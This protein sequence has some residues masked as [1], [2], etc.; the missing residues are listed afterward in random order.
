MHARMGVTR[1]DIRLPFRRI[2]TWEDAKSGI[3]RL[4]DT[5]LLPGDPCVEAYLCLRLVTFLVSVASA[6]TPSLVAPMRNDPMPLR[7]IEISL[8]SC[9]CP[10]CCCL[11]RLCWKSEQLPHVPVPSFS[12]CCHYWETP[13]QMV[14]GERKGNL[15]L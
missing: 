7:V 10:C 13:H 1:S 4:V 8:D 6:W 2:C 12:Y 14:E 3:S 15:F 9:P 5:A 11:F